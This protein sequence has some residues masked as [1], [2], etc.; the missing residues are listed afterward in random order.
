MSSA[1]SKAV[2]TEQLPPGPW[3]VTQ[4]SSQ[5]CHCNLW[6]GELDGIQ[7]WH[8][9]ESPS[10]ISGRSLA[11]YTYQADNHSTKDSHDW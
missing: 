10:H 9:D 3:I 6:P 5:S 2:M 4:I 7:A 1:Q 11:K 8:T